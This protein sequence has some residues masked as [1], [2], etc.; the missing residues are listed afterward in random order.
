MQ[1]FKKWTRLLI[2]VF[3]QLVLAWRRARTR[4]RSPSSLPRPS[5][6]WNPYLRTVTPGP[7]VCRRVRLVETPH[8]CWVEGVEGCWLF[9]PPPSIPPSDDTPPASPAAWLPAS[10]GVSASPQAQTPPDEALAAVQGKNTHQRLFLLTVAVALVALNID[11]RADQ[12]FLSHFLRQKCEHNLSK[13]EFNPTSIK[14][15]IQL[16][17]VWVSAYELHYENMRSHIFWSY[18]NEEK[19][20]PVEYTSI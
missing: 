13:P 2:L 9:L 8:S 11:K 20:R 17:A 10:G 3:L 16:V 18:F 19:H 6:K 5:M 7:S 14:F 1:M 4:R 15:K 12:L